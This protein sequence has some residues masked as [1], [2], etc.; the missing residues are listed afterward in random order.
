MILGLVDFIN[1]L[2][3]LDEAFILYTIPSG[4]GE[5]ENNTI[6]TKATEPLHLTCL[7]TI[8]YQNNGNS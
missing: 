6:R 5:W 2:K 1:L 8:K 7:K 3:I 4:K